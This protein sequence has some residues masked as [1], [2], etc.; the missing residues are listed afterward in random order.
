MP[1]LRTPSR[2]R[3]LLA[4]ALLVLAGLQLDLGASAQAQLPST[5]LL[6]LSIEEITTAVTDPTVVEVAEDGTVVIAERKGAIKLVAPD[7]TQT[8][9]GTIGVSAN[10]CEECPA[11]DFA[12]EEGG[13]HG[14]LLYPDFTESGRLLAYYSVPGSVGDRPTPAV[15][16]D[17]GGD[18][19]E[20]GLFRLSA[21]TVSDGQL[22]LA[23]EEVLFENATEWYECCHYGGD[24]EWLAD[25]TLVMSTG[26]DTNPHQSSGYSPHDQNDGRDAFNAL[27]TSQNPADRRGKIL[28]IDVR[29]VDGDGS[30]IPA[31][32]PHVDDPAYDPY[33]YAMG[34]RSN[35]RIDVDPVSQAIIVGNVGPDARTPDSTR[36]PEGHDE[37]EVVPPGGGTNHGWPMCIGDNE[38][39][40]QFADFAAESPGEAYDCSAMTPAQIHYTYHPDLLFPTLANGVTRTAI[41]GPVYRYDGDGEHAWP[42]HYQGQFALLEF[43]R[44]SMH[45]VPFDA[46]TA[47]LDTT[48]IIPAALGGL[49]SPI[50]ATVGPDGAL[51][52]AEYGAGFYNATGGAISRVVPDGPASALP[53]A[54]QSGGTDATAPAL[55]AGGALLVLVTPVR[56]RQLV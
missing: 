33:V 1:S 3:V 22:D 18:P 41:A 52:V 11:E 47:S 14:L 13:L 6:D 34:F 56:R 7:G 54:P 10:V 32:N 9:A 23:S 43:S 49:T 4:L 44:Q 25:G 12:L 37:V 51:Y 24:L 19:A 31:D 36:G 50:D 16:A 40:V 8:L 42:A 39:Y 29:D 21:F 46:E 27:R 30:M 2:L 5:G 38:P 28:R 35:Y 17:A 20:E 15:H 48:Q 53:A 55:L 26:D 45:L